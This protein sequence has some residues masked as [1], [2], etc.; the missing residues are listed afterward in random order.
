MAGEVGLV[1]PVP[2][3]VPVPLTFTLTLIRTRTLTL[4][5][6]RTLD[7][8]L[9]QPTAPHPTSSRP[10]P[11]HATPRQHRSVFVAGR[12]PGHHAGARGAV[13][14]PTFWRKPNDC[15]CG[16]CLVNHAGE[17]T[18]GCSVGLVR[19]TRLSTV[20]LLSFL[21]RIFS[22]SRTI[23]PPYLRTPVHPSAIA[24]AYARYKHGREGLKVAIVDFDIHHGNGTEDIVKNLKPR[25]VQLPLPPSWPAQVRVRC[26]YCCVGVTI[27]KVIIDGFPIETFIFSAQKITIFLPLKTPAL[28]AQ[29]TLPH[30]RTHPLTHA[31]T[32]PPTHATPSPVPPHPQALVRRERCRQRF[33]RFH[34]PGARGD[35]LLP[36]IG[37]GRRDGRR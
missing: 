20:T 21:P 23:V 15:S 13:P 14:S 24:A 37:R 33:L 4:T 6:T 32:H 26:S 1:Q 9:T 2:V 19:T 29:P 10:T 25:S 35:G 17:I 36:G 28:A 3:P 22:S 5:L 18:C 12:P 30:P 8:I 16:F 11:R 7:S 34:Q 31:R 27:E